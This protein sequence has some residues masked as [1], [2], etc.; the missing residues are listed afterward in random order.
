MLQEKTQKILNKSPTMKN[1]E[2]L[3]RSMTKA[4]IKENVLGL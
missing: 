4:F 2:I 1:V 3:A